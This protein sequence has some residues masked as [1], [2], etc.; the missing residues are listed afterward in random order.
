MDNFGVPGL[1]IIQHPGG[2]FRMQGQNRCR[3]L[4]STAAVYKLTTDQT[5]TTATRTNVTFNTE[6]FDTD[7]LHSIITLTD[8]LFAPIAGKYIVSG[9]VRWENIAAAFGRLINI[10]ANDATLISENDE[11]REFSGNWLFMTASPAVVSLAA[12]DYVTLQVYHERG[13][14]A[15][16]VADTRTQFSMAY[17]GE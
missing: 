5:I 3:Y 14:D 17:V 8:R 15:K 4:N 16:I 9:S 12:G 11:T 2:R 7:N 6:Q 10:V 13:S 1:D